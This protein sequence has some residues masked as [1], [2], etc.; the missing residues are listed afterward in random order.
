M[1]R[2]RIETVG[3]NVYE[4]QDQFDTIESGELKS[5]RTDIASHYQGDGEPQASET[6]EQTLQGD[7]AVELSGANA[8]TVEQAKRE[9]DR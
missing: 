6:S 8:A 1:K 3:V 7:P 5:L 4:L 2:K 9:A